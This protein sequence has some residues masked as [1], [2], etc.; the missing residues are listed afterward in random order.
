MS[1]ITCAC[2]SAET[3]VSGTELCPLCNDPDLKSWLA[4]VEDFKSKNH[5]ADLSDPVVIEK[6]NLKW[7]FERK[8]MIWM[9]RIIYGALPRD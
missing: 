9:K 1:N 3:N 6:L 5:G 8:P 4:F 7:L 2:V